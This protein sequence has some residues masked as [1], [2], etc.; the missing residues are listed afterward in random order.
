MVKFNKYRHLASGLGD[1]LRMFPFFLLSFCLCRSRSPT[2]TQGIVFSSLHEKDINTYPYKRAYLQPF[3]FPFLPIQLPSVPL[4]MLPCA[5]FNHLQYYTV[6][7]SFCLIGASWDDAHREL[8][9]VRS[10]KNLMLI[11]G[12]L[13]ITHAYCRVLTVERQLFDYTHAE[14]RRQE[15][16]H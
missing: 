3:K 6:K 16:R 14:E 4:P 2:Q 10:S 5:I 11:Q 9:A 15:F 1:P 7:T 13:C 8:R 12:E